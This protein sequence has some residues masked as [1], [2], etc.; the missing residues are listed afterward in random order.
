MR[1]LLNKVWYDSQF[2]PIML[3]LEENDRARIGDIK[4]IPASKKETYLCVPP[5]WTHEDLQKFLVSDEFK[6]R[7]TT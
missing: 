7:E 5:S 3:L 4:P 1:V 2:V 6:K